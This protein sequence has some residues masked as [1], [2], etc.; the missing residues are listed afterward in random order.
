M[1]LRDLRRLG[2]RVWGGGG[3]VAGGPSQ[4]RSSC[5]GGNERQS[6][7]FATGSSS[8]KDLEADEIIPTGE[9]SGSSPTLK[10][11]SSPGRGKVEL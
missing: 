8:I 7:A 6:L 2:H 11:K 3:E 10:V 5:P 1:K 4:G 9:T